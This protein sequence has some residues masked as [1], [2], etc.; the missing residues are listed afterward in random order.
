[1]IKKFKGIVLLV[2]VSIVLQ[3]V[4][5]V[6]VVKA[7]EDKSVSEIIDE[8]IES[9]KETLG[10]LS[11]T[12]EKLYDKL[13]G[14]FKKIGTLS[15]KVKKVVDLYNSLDETSEDY[16]QRLMDFFEQYEQLGP[17]NRKIVDFCT[18]LLSA[19]DKLV[20]S[21]KRIVVVDLY[22][23]KM[24]DTNLEGN[25]SFSSENEAVAIIEDGSF[26]KPVSI[27]MTKVIAT[28]ESHET[29]TLRIFVKKPILATSFKLKK[30]STVNIPL[31]S[32]DNIGD[33]KISSEKMISVERSGK[34]L[35]VKGISKGTAYIYVGSHGL[36]GKTVKYKIRVV[37]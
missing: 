16:P 6:T 12:L 20:A 10:S 5:P 11:P 9:D 2:V 13:I 27:G 32:E 21:V 1:M 30:G 15:R 34:T 17:V 3:M 25:V 35:T 22:S 18:G 7:E 26:V 4:L 31:T 36:N 14:V 23:D 29:E 24:L 8:I 19:K 37:K 28:N 33:I